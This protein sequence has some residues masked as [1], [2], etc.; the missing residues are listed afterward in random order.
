DDLS[1]TGPEAVLR[2]D[3][4]RA[5]GSQRAARA[6]DVVAASASGLDDAAR[7]ADAERRQIDAIA[8]RTGAQRE[9]DGETGPADPR[10]DLSKNA[11]ELRRDLQRIRQGSEISAAGRL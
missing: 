7:S 11:D 6:S 4:F 5:R 8:V 2:R 9:W 10:S 1:Y 3:I